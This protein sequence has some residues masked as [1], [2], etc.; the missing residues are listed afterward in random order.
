MKTVT[1][2]RD[3]QAGYTQSQIIPAGSRVRYAYDHEK[4][5]LPQIIGTARETGIEHSVSVGWEDVFSAG[6]RVEGGEG[7]DYDTGTIDS[8][9]RFPMPHSEQI[10]SA[11][12]LVAA[13]RWDSGATTNSP[14]NTLAPI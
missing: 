10:E 6:S 8:I 5:A 4:Q 7:E 11:W 2:L 3:V 12:K 9:S 13:V 1:L 14:I